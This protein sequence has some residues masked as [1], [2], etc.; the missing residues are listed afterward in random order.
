MIEQHAKCTLKENCPSL[1]TYH[2]WRLLWDAGENS[3]EASRQHGDLNTPSSEQTSPELLDFLPAVGNGKHFYLQDGRVKYPVVAWIRLF[4]FCAYDNE[5]IKLIGG[6]HMHAQV[7]QMKFGVGD[8]TTQ[9]YK[10]DRIWRKPYLVRGAQIL[11]WH[12]WKDP[13]VKMIDTW[14]CLNE[15]WWLL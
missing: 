2:G 7:S 9:P 12:E 1:R 11:S 13:G 5:A 14:R 15:S 4:I 6:R 8:W 3:K 10:E